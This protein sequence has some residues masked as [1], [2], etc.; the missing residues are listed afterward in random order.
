MASQNFKQ[1]SL[2]EHPVISKDLT[3]LRDASSDTAQFR[4]ALKRI[5][6]ILAYHALKELPLRTFEIET[7]IQKTTGYDIDQDVMVVPILRAGLG[8]SDAL[9]QFIPDAK[10][11]HLG[12][13]RNETTHEPED[14][15]SNIPKG[16]EDAMVLVVDP[17]LATGGSA[18]DA[19]SF[20]KKQG[21]QHLRFV[22]LVCAP[23]GL[24]KMEQEHPDVH[25]ITAAID[26]KLNDDA[27]IVPGLGDA[28]DRYFGTV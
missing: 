3:I 13:E 27:F 5:A 28:G 26:E 20:L 18:N 25:I 22:S 23:E 24:K 2:I 1:V 21:A 9:L 17:M 19:L 6:I 15:Y 16:V 11:G 10:V 7:P 12:M 4:A 8:L 14:Y